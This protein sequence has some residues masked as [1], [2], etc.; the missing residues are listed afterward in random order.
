MGLP[1]HAFEVFDRGTPHERRC[2]DDLTDEHLIDLYGYF[3][4]GRRNGGT[5]I[6]QW[7]KDKPHQVMMRVFCRLWRHEHPA[8]PEHL[9]PDGLKASIDGLVDELDATFGGDHAQVHPVLHTNAVYWYL[10]G[11]RDAAQGGALEHVDV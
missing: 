6:V 9:V 1:E 5:D 7:F 8:P 2:G 10:R 3:M 4:S 11:Q